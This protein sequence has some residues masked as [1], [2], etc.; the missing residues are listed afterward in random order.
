MSLRLEFDEI[1][2]IELAEL[3]KREE[4]L[5]LIDVRNPDEI[6]EFYIEMQRKTMKTTWGTFHE[7]RGTFHEAMGTFHDGQGTFHE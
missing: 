5:N 4:N 6:E 1:N 2:V 7:G 3:I